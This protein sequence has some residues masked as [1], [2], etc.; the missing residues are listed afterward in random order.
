MSTAEEV[1]SATAGGG[2]D[3]LWDDGVQA[4]RE[5]DY[6]RAAELFQGVLDQQGDGASA[7]R[8]AAVHQ[9]LGITLLRLRR[10]E[11][12]VMELQR[13]VQ[14]N[15]YDGR[16]RYKLGLGLARLGRSDEALASLEQS[17]RLSPNVAEHHWRLGEELRRQGMEIAARQEIR[18]ALELDPNHAAALDT[19]KALKGLELRF[20][21]RWVRRI[22]S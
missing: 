5:R 19:M 13:S 7:L 1:R 6:A 15:P 20:M 14:L 9:Q 17:V 18:E 10:T 11:E 8:A 16:T 4:F 21:L 2:P 12:G 3:G 22:F